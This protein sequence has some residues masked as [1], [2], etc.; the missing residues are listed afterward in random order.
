MDSLNCEKVILI[1]D[2]VELNR[3]ILSELF[4]KEYG[5]LEAENGL[6]A[7]DLIE[8]YGENIKVVLLDLVMPVMDGFEVLERLKKSRWFRQIPIILI[9]AENNEST[10]L[11]GY[12]IGVTDIINKPFNPEIVHRRVTNIIELYDHKR[13]LET[14]LQEQYQLLEQQAEK[15][16]KVNS[17][18]IDTL[19]TAVEFRNSESG[20]HI[21]RMRKITE[22]LLRAL[23]ARHE[24]YRF[25]QEQ[26][27]I[28]S[29]AAALHDIG[30]IAIPDAVLLKPGR[31]TPEE[32]EV[33][34]THT[35]KG[36]EILESLNYA[37]DEEYF[38]YSYEICRHHHE[39]WD[40]KGYPDGLKGDEIPIWAQVVSLAD[41][42]E[43]L[44]GERIYKPVYSH[45]KAVSMIVNGECGQFNPSLLS[46]FLEEI[47]GLLKELKQPEMRIVRP[48]ALNDAQGKA[49]GQ[50]ENISERTLRL[51]EL[52]R[53]KYRVLSDLS[54]DITFDYDAQTDVLTFSEKYAEMFG[55][56]FQL[57]DALHTI[58]K[59][60]KI[61]KESKKVIWKELRK[62]APDHPVAKMEIQMETVSGNFEWFEVL[63]NALWRNES[64]PECVSLIGKMTNINDIK[65]ETSRLKKQANTDS[66]TGTYNRKAAVEIISDYLLSESMPSGALFF[67]DIDDFKSFNDDFGHQYGDGIL[68][69]IGEKLKGTFRGTDVVG[70][71]GGDEFIV[72]LEEINSREAITR[73][74]QEVCDLFGQVQ[75]ELDCRQK[76]TGSVG[77][78]RSPEDG[79]SFD[80]LLARADK[81]LY[82]AK[83]SGKNQFSFYSDLP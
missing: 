6:D 1:V 78:A 38:H 53:Q 70:R 59:T 52:E 66:L 25:S 3:A 27:N 50:P 18:V 22:Y 31:L 30:K 29:D 56:S 35:T 33:M 73:K 64:A 44:T 60:D 14:K 61:L 36:C 9:T 51:L 26:I 11:K 42:Y 17:F 62:L 4:R 48:P 71:I 13:D 16:K 69:K 72:F 49:G 2:D 58:Q 34:K 32:F 47:D 24:Q 21:A 75:E 46:C 10:A 40:G 39:R 63:I 82:Q 80:V 67:V 19:S 55:G 12:A 15:L 28:I 79:L 37:Q 65:L 81:A 5:I 23:S 57:S 54:G 8:K 74:A 76:I 7:L 45:E 20:F 43:A 77:I 41:V 83:N 68:Q